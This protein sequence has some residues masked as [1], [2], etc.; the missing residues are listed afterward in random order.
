MTMPNLDL[1]EERFEHDIEAYMLDN[2]YEQF[3]YQDEQPVVDEFLKLDDENRFAFRG[4]V[5]K[6]NKVYSFV[7]QLARIHDEDLFKEYLFTS[8]LISMLPKKKVPPFWI[9]DK[10]RLEFTSLKQTFKGAITLGEGQGGVVKPINST[11]TPKDKKKKGTPEAIIEKV[12]EKYSGDFTDSDR[13][14]I[15]GILNMFMNDDEIKKYKKY[16]KDNNPEVFVKS[17][18]PDKFKDIVT[19]CFLE[20]NDTFKKLFNDSD[21]YSKVMEAMAKELYK[22]LR[23][24]EK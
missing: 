1:T 13:V 2:G 4:L 24:E 9:D 16:A 14:I 23:S 22:E 8:H 3:S 20:N 21:F 15:S 17:L 5:K 10:I 18:F 19:K 7:T 11:S 12:N 6:F